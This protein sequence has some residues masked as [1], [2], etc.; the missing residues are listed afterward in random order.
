MLSPSSGLKMQ[1]VCYSEALVS[2]YKSTWRQNPEQL[3]H[4]TGVDDH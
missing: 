1:T 4:L 2:A 3:H